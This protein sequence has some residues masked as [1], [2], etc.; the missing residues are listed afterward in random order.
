MTTSFVNIRD[1]GFW[2]Q[3]SLLCLWMRLVALHIECGSN[4]ADTLTRLRNEWMLQS[5]IAVPGVVVTDLNS[6]A[7]DN[8]AKQAISA[9]IHMVLSTLPAFDEAIGPK[10]LNLLGVGRWNQS[11]ETSRLVEIARAFLDL[12]QGRIETESNRTDFMPGSRP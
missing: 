6:V 10:T 4:G 11:I 8:A 5:G 7:D 1:K 12:L 3:D 2:M 9:A